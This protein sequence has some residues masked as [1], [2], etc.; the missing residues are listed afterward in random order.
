MAVAF[1]MSFENDGR[2]ALDLYDRVCAE[3]GVN[4]RAPEGLVYHWAAKTETG[5]L[6]VVDVWTSQADFDRFF[7]ELLGPAFAKLEV[8]KPVVETFEV[9]NTIAGRVPTNA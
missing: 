7:H 2:I 3:M 5:G 6:R 9:H 4:D 8:P 1:I